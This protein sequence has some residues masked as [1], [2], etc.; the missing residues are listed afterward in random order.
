MTDTVVIDTPARSATSAR[1]MRD[2]F[3]LLFIGSRGDAKERSTS[4]CD[5]AIGEAATQMRPSFL[6][7]WATTQAQDTPRAEAFLIAHN[8]LSSTPWHSGLLLSPRTRLAHA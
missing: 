8:A 1:V 6:A 5:L 7:T 2:P 4:A 3:R